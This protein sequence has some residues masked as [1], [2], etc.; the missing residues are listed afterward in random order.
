MLLS[1]G[2]ANVRVSLGSKLSSQVWEAW[3]R[4][5]VHAVPSISR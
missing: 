1:M 2:V 4:Y 3:R 5:C